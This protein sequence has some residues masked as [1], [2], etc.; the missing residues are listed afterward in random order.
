MQEL[1][2][3]LQQR[4]PLPDVD[5]WSALDKLPVA[6]VEQVGLDLDPQGRGWRFLFAISDKEALLEAITFPVAL[7]AGLESFPLALALESRHLVQERYALEVFPR[8]R[9]THTIVGYP[10]GAG[11][12]E[13]MARLAGP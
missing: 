9:H 4:L 11:R 5:W 8:Y 2:P 13:S 1:T 10:G 6:G 12:C 3:S 7:R